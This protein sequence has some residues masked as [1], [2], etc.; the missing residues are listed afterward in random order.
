MMD[1]FKES[2]KSTLDSL[3]QVD[4]SLSEALIE[5]SNLEKLLE[6]D[7]DKYVYFQQ[8][9]DYISVSSDFLGE[10]ALLVEVLE[11]EMQK[12]HEDRARSISKR[13]AADLAD[14]SSALEPAI[15]AAMRVIDDSRSLIS[16]NQLAAAISAA[17]AAATTA[18]E[19]SRN[20][21]VKLDEFGR[22][23]NKQKS[24]LTAQSRE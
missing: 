6:A 8:L 20:L 3:V 2:H 15:K 12:L 22:D 23:E 19:A 9:R 7:D 11:E 10:K 21:P 24:N 14:G 5:I 13:R 18:M 4:T 1:K 16:S 17:Q